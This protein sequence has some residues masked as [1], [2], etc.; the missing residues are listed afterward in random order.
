MIMLRFLV[1]KMRKKGVIALQLNWIFVLII[2][3]IILTFFIVIVQKQRE[4]S[5]QTIS[6]AIQTDL[7]AIFASSAVSTGTASIVEVPSREISFS[8]EGFK[9]GNQFAANFP[10][11]FAPDLIKSDRNTISIYAY[12]WSIPMRITNLLFQQQTKI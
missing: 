8:C 12:D 10:Y 6:G 1:G 4:V 3:A 11:A 2:G 5:E 9:V 7:Q